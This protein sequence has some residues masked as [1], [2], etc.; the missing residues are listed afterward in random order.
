MTLRW[1]RIKVFDHACLLTCALI[2]ATLG[3]IERVTPGIASAVLA[4]S[5]ARSFPS[6]LQWLGI[7]RKWTDFP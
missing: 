5:S 7:H 4:A 6:M 1:W 2:W 3:Q